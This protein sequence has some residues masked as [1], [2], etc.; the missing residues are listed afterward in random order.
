MHSSP[1]VAFRSIA[2]T[3]YAFISN[4][5]VKI[6][7]RGE[8]N[9]G[10]SV[11]SNRDSNVFFHTRLVFGLIQRQRLPPL[12][13][14]NKLFHM[15]KVKIGA[16]ILGTKLWPIRFCLTIKRMLGQKGSYKFGI[17]LILVALC[18][19]VPTV[20]LALFAMTPLQSGAQT[21]SIIEIHKGQ[22]PHEV[23]KILLAQGAI[24]D[25]T[26]FFWLGRL[27]RQWKHIKAGEYR[28]SPSMSPLDLMEV[29]TSGISIAHPVTVREGENMYEIA[30]DIA[31]KKLA[32]RD[33]FLSLCKDSAF[34]ASLDVFKTEAP[35]TLEGFLFPDTYFFNR[36]LTDSEMIK[37]M[38]RHY[39][40]FW[41]KKQQ[42]RARELGMS[43]NEITT[44]ASMIEK[45]TGAP[46]ERA[47]ISSVFHNRLKKHMK[48]QSD[49]TTIY[50][51]WSR[52]KGKIHKSD[53]SV[54]NDYNTYSVSALPIGPIGNPGKEALSAA[55]YPTE[56]PYLYFVSH[57][58]GTHQFS[59]TFEEHNQAVQ[60]FQIDPKARQGKSWR[61]HLKR[62]ASVPAH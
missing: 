3:Q 15:S 47:V 44:L 37:Q 7:S 11:Y 17:I 27:T 48:L 50:G 1:S 6:L 39:F 46:E 26:H 38:V 30:D 25:T 18:V 56:S 51:M 13:S 45:E 42:D 14:S 61:D 59:R 52:Y 49:P 5:N 10:F 43:R 33:H 21:S 20:R 35:A 36:A 53:L 28:V 31:A 4:F 12:T 23:T 57:N 19:G 2:A 55:L 41:S 60:K 34:I 22:N 29:L 9:I 16:K 54:K 8:G 58:D 24:S 32:S 40:D 62:P